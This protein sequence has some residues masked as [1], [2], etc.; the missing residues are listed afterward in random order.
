MTLALWEADNLDAR[1]VAILIMNPDPLSADELDHMVRLLGSA[2]AAEWL[3]SYVI[4][5]HSEKERLYLKWMQ[6][7]DRWAV[8]AGWGLTSSRIKQNPAG[9]DIPSLLNRIE[10]KMP[11]AVPEVQWTVNF[12]LAGICI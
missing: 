10:K 2:Q 1:H 9:L 11:N 12:W 4:R 5:Q 6:A 8:C 7:E 3:S